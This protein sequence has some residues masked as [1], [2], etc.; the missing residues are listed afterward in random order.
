[1]FQSLRA[2]LIAVCVTITIVSM[3]AL[4][5][6]IFVMVRNDTQESLDARI[7][8]LT[9]ARAEQVAAWAQEKQRI[10]GAL[11]AVVG[12]PEPVPFLLRIKEA[13]GFDNAFYV[14]ADKTAVFPK[15]RPP[16]YDGTARPWYKLAAA[17]GGPA[18][19]PAYADTSTGKLTISFVDPVKGPD[20]Q[21]QAVVGSDVFL[22]TIAQQV[23]SIRPTEKS[24]AFMADDSGKILA[25][26]KP[27]LALK[28]VSDIAAD[29]TPTLL[30][31]LAQQGGHAVVTVDGQPTML[32]A[33]KIDGT[34]WTLAVAI[35]RAHATQPVRAMLQV[36]A[37]ITTLCVIVAVLLMA[38][39][40]RHLLRRL[41]LVRNA[42]HD[43]ASGEGDLTR[44]LDT[45]GHDELSQ[46]AQAFNRFVDKIAAV[47]VR[48]RDSSESVR[49]TT[50]EIASGNRDLSERTE[51]QASSLQTTA[52]AMEQL[53][54]TVRQN[55]DNARE[56]SK[57]ASQ[58]SDVAV[59]GGSV[60]D[61]VVH[62]M[63]NIDASSKKIADIIGVIDSIAF[64]TNILALNAAVE[65]ARAGEQG[66]GF[67]V[68]AA[69]VRAL[70]GRSATAAKEIKALI[71]ESV[72]QVSTGSKLVQDAGAT[73]SQVVQS[74]K[75][76][77]SIVAEIDHASQEQSSGIASIGTSVHDMDQGTQQN[78]ALVE[79]SAAAAQSLHHQAIQL[80]EAVAGF[81]VEGGGT[82]PQPRTVP[83]LAE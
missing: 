63:G 55:A 81:K 19:T 71:D 14:Q 30:T 5:G 46:I 64:Q 22:T 38:F 23:T 65:A 77:S 34:P 7:S 56:A 40:V 1:M 11:K 15:P 58:A 80:A 31:Q 59:R 53:T 17:T 13:G 8:Q 21:L 25:Y 52:S 6:G 12:N 42:L 35:D 74:V 33:S 3:L 51:R 83:T 67:A 20:G 47:L 79:E 29:L 10:T 44:R 78:A 68:V 36:A 24:F 50:Q 37:V 2:R 75:Q 26:S 9:R 28:P 48:I 73:M 54:G 39:T 27:E 62:T 4:A 41:N 82:A 66:R 69:E 57:L 72:A 49:S 16:E 60:V 76:V 18:I 43:I 32:Y 70:A 45:E 61:E